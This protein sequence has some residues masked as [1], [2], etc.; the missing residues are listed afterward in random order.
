MPLAVRSCHYQASGRRRRRSS[1]HNRVAGSERG[2]CWW[3]VTPAAS[4]TRA[5]SEAMTAIA[6]GHLLTCPAGQNAIA[7]AVIRATQARRCVVW[8]MTRN[9]SPARSPGHRA[10]G[11][12][13]AGATP[14]ASCTIRL[15]PRC[16]SPIPRRPGEAQL[17][18]RRAAL[19]P[20]DDPGDARG[21]RH[22]GCASASMAPRPCLSGERPALWRSPPLGRTAR[23]AHR[24]RGRSG[25]RLGQHCQGFSAVGLP[26]G[27][28]RA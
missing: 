19:H 22:P 4:Q 1:G 18:P 2:S 10:P 17:E 26:D 21:G 6:A 3:L 8:L 5:P 24:T 15:A 11:T 28:A 14:A 20:C 13:P 9:A 12:C 16:R 27:R 23:P 25:C 7:D